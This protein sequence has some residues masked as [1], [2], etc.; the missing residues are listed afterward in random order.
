[1]KAGEGHLQCGRGHPG[2]EKLTPVTKVLEA[3]CPPQFQGSRR[4][5]CGEPPGTFLIH[6]CWS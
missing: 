3:D 4:K 6:D 1:M 5:E 2:E